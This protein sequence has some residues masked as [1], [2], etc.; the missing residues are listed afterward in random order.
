LQI[1]ALLS[2]QTDIL[3]F[4]EQACR[5]RSG[6]LSAQE[7]AEVARTLQLPLSIASVNTLLR[8]YASVVEPTKICFEDVVKDMIG[9]A[10]ATMAATRARASSPNPDFLRTSSSALDV[11]P[12]MPVC[13]HSSCST[14]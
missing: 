7:F 2:E 6:L 13:A 10:N 3:A 11:R 12:P 14:L 8:Q 5:D 9:V 4:F 1:R